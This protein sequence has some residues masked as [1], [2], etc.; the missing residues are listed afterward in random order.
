RLALACYNSL[1]KGWHPTTALGNMAAAA[2]AARVFQLSAEQTLHAMALGFVQL[3]GTTQFIADGALA[4]RVG[5]GFA[6]RSGLLAAHLARAG[7]TGP[8]R[9]LEGEA[10]LF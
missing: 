4:K 10:G 6:A 5:P 8:C 9:F 1:G 2:A 3:S 7:I